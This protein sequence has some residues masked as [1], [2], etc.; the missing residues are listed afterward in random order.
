MQGMCF[1]CRLNGMCLYGVVEVREGR[2]DG[3]RTC[4]TSVW[5]RECLC[6]VF[7]VWEGCEDGV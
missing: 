3:E 2:G 7:E 5:N 6:D 4:F 1:T